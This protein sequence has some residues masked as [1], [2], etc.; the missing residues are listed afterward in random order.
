MI[1]INEQCTGC[2]ACMN[3]CPHEAITVGEDHK[4][5]IIPIVD[6]QKCVGCGLCEQTCN[7][8]KSVDNL[9]H[10][11]NLYSFVINDKK[12]LFNS[13]SGG[14]FTALSD[15]ILKCGGVVIGAICDAGFTVKHVIAESAG[16]RDRMRGS[17]YVQS[18][19]GFVYQEA[20]RLL[21]DGRRVM[22]VGTPCQVAALRSYLGRDYD[23]LTT[24]D[25]LCHGV[26]N[27]RLF[28]D[29]IGFMEWQ[30]GK[31]VVE[32][33]FRGKK[34]A[35]AAAVQFAKYDDN[36]TRASIKDQAYYSFFA[37]LSLRDSC[38][39]CK[40]RSP[41]RAGDITIADFWGLEKLTNK[42][43][44]KGISK[45]YINTD[46][47]QTLFE[48]ARRCAEVHEYSIAEVKDKSLCKSSHNP[49]QRRELFWDTY[50][51]EGYSGLVAK[52]Y[53]PSLY[54]RARF[55]IKKI[56]KQF[57]SKIDFG[58]ELNR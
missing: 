5:F 50:H 47:G 19:P 30:Y 16:E 43:Y 54:R 42:K 27:N 8:G 24:I 3:I 39:Q 4:G 48:E 2:L 32:Y 22:F 6:S 51:N 57:R 11:K 33:S 10:V 1:T 31:K 21:Q 36:K 7:I 34:F 46:K 44:P 13:T 55:V 23:N 14:A 45:V 35:A 18:N 37:G 53:R 38:Y 26:P 58:R 25:F 9:N 20:E 49:K 41:H 17:K 12:A 52:F 40:Y 29:H 15:V 28:K 56:A